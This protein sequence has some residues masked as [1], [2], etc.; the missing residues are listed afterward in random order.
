AWIA[1]WGGHNGVAQGLGGGDWAEAI[2]GEVYGLLFDKLLPEVVNALDAGRPYW[3]SS[4]H[5]PYG[6]REDHQNPKWGDSHLWNVWHGR[7]PFEWYHTRTDRFV[8]EFGFQSF[9]PPKTIEGFTLPEDRNI[10]SYVMEHHQRSAI[11]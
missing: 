9:P 2:S 1:L 3:P 5:S 8:S 10:T 7:Q 4:G 11:G 6:D